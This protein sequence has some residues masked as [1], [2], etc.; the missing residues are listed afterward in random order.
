LAEID[1]AVGR[2][3]EDAAVEI[4]PRQFPVDEPFRARGK[5]G[6]GMAFRPFRKPLGGLQTLR[7]TMVECDYGRLATI[8]HDCS[9]LLELHRRRSGTA[10]LKFLHTLPQVR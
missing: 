2:F 10:D 7:R 9:L 4:E 5:L 3:L 6:C 8:S 1:I